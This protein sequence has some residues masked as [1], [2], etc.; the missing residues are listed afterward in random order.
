M[1]KALRGLWRLT[2]AIIAIRIVFI[3][4]FGM[5]PQDAYYDFYGQHLAWSYY[6]HPPMIAYLLRGFTSLFGKKVFVLKLADSLVSAGTVWLFYRLARKFLTGMRI[7]HAVILLLSTLLVTIVSLVS[8]P[9]VPMLFFWTAT[10]VTLHDAVFEGRRSS[11]IWAGILTGLT[12]DSKY[13]GLFL[14]A[15]L[16]C[17]LVLSRKHR[18]WLFSRWF[19]FYLLLFLA[20]IFPVVYWNMQ[21]NFASFKFQSAGRVNEG[22]EF[23]IFNFLG[24]LGH[25]SAVLVPILFFALFYFLWKTARRFGLRPQQMP[26]HTLFLLSF[27]LPLFL[28]FL[29]I[30]IFYWVKINWLMPAYITGIL[31]VASYINARWVRYQLI[32]SFVIHTALAIEIIFLVVPIN[33][34][35]TWV[36]WQSMATQ[37]AERRKQ[38]PGAFIFSADDYKTSAVLNFYLPETVYAK[39]IVGQRALQFDY[40]GTDLETLRGRNALFIDSNPGF[41]SLQNEFNIPPFYYYY[42]DHIQ[43][44]QPILVYRGGKPVR[45]FSTFLCI[46][47]HPPVK[48]QVPAPVNRH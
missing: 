45:K 47:Y 38:Y 37:V 41:D 11:W 15:G 20:T 48:H 6:D 25:Q 17:F 1:N 23:D 43:A 32:F 4:V 8:T 27:F 40:V 35:D 39:N 30:S 16:C 3:F 33:G 10:L 44:L 14:V 5:M 46:G 36:G 21:N 18:H 7:Q 31:W 9:D 19:F 28:G 13:T 22:F 34:D 24:T 42:F 26:D 12:F 29:F 2:V